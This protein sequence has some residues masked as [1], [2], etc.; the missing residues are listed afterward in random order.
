MT[1]WPIV[2]GAA[3]VGTIRPVKL[4]LVSNVGLT[5][6]KS[7]ADSISNT[8]PVSG[9]DALAIKFV[10]LPVLKKNESAAQGIAVNAAIA[11]AMTHWMAR[12]RSVA[13]MATSMTG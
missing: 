7:S 9:R 2:G 12:G 13:C 10:T 3:P 4:P 8:P 6:R 1:I 5:S 11:V